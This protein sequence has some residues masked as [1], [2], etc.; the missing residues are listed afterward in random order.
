MAAK[1]VPNQLSSCEMRSIEINAEYFGV[2]L[3]QLMEN[4]GRNVAQEI[5]KRFSN[6]KKVV[7]F[8]GLGGNGGDGFVAA[9]HLLVH[10]YSVTIFLA[11][12]S[13]DI[14]HP[15]AVQNWNTL[16]LVGDCLQ[17]VEVSDIS[18]VS[19]VGV[20]V[21]VDAL[22]GTG[23]KGTLKAHILR[24]VEVIN[25]FEGFKIAVDVPTGIN[26]DS[27]EVLGGAV[28][29]D[30]T[31]T[32]Y[33]SKWGLN[34][35]KEFVGDL[36]VRDIGL[37][38]EFER[39][40][41]PGDVNLVCKRHVLGVHK[42]DFGRLLVIGGSNVF[43]GAPA[44]ASIAA[45]RSG[46]DVVYT[47]S[48]EKT[49]NAISMMSPDLISVKLQGDNLNRDNVV[50]LEPYL[51]LVDAVV[52][53]PG[54]GL[55]DETCKFVELF[56][57]K[58]EK[59]G[60]PLLLDADGL[61]AFAKFKRP[62]KSPL[63]LTPHIGEYAVLTG[64][65]LPED[66]FE[67]KVSLIQKTAKALNAVLLVKGKVDIIC[68]PSRVKLNFTGNLGMTVGG[69]GDVLAGI[70]GGLLAQKTD[71]FKAAVAGAFVNGACGDIV[72]S[73]IGFHMLASDLLDVIPQM[74]IKPMDHLKVR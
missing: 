47:A 13:K 68:S 46:I 40:A 49:A 33:K 22:L 1:N 3:L 61:K 28:R 44:L 26:S 2:S 59:A 41:G 73:R 15:S 60:K 56:V 7:F 52:L 43:S 66:D 16:K 57:D 63:V 55:A 62:L 29:A 4:A 45:L 19:L 17:I 12:K 34:R 42:G 48:V 6:M 67:G 8:C 71:V 30:L 9:R 64:Q 54:I 20:D 11:G 39:F 69:T 37:P 21:V 51:A 23:T 25:S 72:A 36:V 53:G 18:N 32:F 74:F 10:G 38:F 70:V 58:V 24:M 31:V 5:E 35:A 65:R 27:G 14:S 50:E